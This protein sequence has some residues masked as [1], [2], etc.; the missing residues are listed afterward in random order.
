VLTGGWQVLMG[1]GATILPDDLFAPVNGDAQPWEVSLDDAVSPIAP[2]AMIQ[3]CTHFSFPLF[4]LVLLT[5]SC[6]RQNPS[7]ILVCQSA[8]I[9]GS[10][11]LGGGGRPLIYAWS[12]V[13]GPTSSAAASAANQLA[14][15][16]VAVTLTNLF[17]GIYVIRLTVTDYIGQTSSSTA[18]VRLVLLHRSLPFLTR[19]RS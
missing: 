4:S 16:Q 9:S 18:T 6:V 15:N 13:S 10:L 12:V 17:P 5:E 8:A 11:S 19:V 14:G 2:Q 3:A 1:Q 7:S